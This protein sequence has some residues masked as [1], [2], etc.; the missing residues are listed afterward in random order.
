MIS[1][2]HIARI[3]H[4]VNRAYC[5]A[6]GDYSQPI[7]EAAPDWQ[8]Q[9][10]RLGV[11]FH[12]AHPDAGPN[13]SH[14]SW[15]AEKQANG[16]TYGPVK[17]PIAKKHPCM[18]PFDELPAEQQAK[19]FLFRGIAHAI[20]DTVRPRSNTVTKDDI[21]DLLS[22]AAITV[23]KVGNKTTLVVCT[24]HNGF[25]LTATSACVDPA[26]YDEAIGKECCMTRIKDELWKLEG[27]KL[28]C[29]LSDCCA[30]FRPSAPLS[31]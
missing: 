11:M 9:S 22:T 4:E 29:L 10:A 5:Q 12:M 14:D 13:A 1:V 19:D 15:L 18:V 7:W 31:L 26:N 24:L 27:Y 2:E 3:A 23:S 6:I 30:C 8:K 21:D 17:D 20:I 16:W 28:Q 25:E